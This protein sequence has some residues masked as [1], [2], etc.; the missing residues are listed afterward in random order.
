VFQNLN[1]LKNIQTAKP[2]DENI[3]YYPLT[4]GKFSSPVLLID[5]PKFSGVPKLPSSFTVTFHKSVPPKE[6]GISDAK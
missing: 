3:K 4:N 2:F 6:P 1:Q 5:S